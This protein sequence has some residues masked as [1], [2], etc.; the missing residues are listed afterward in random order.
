[1]SKEVK[2][3]LV[4]EYTPE[5][6]EQREFLTRAARSVL[7]TGKSIALAAELLWE[8]ESGEGGI[9]ACEWGTDPWLP[10]QVFQLV[11]DIYRK[12][13][14]SPMEKDFN[15]KTFTFD[16]LGNAERLIASFKEGEI[17]FC[18]EF[19]TW[20]I[21]D[22]NQ[23]RFVK[24]GDPFLRA[25]HGYI[26]EQMLEEA[27]NSSNEERA[28]ALYKWATKSRMKHRV[29]AA[30]NMAK[31]LVLISE[32]RLDAQP[33]LFACE[34]GVIDLRT[35]ELRDA[36]PSDL[37]SK[38]GGPRFDPESLR[39]DVRSSDWDGF[40]QKSIPDEE[41]RRFLQ[42]AAGYSLTGSTIE[43]KFFYLYGRPATGKSTFVSA[44]MQVLGEYARVADT[45]TFTRSSSGRGAGAAS[46][47][48]ARLAGARLVVTQEVEEGERFAS[49]LVSQYT[50]GDPVSA[51]FL[52]GSTFEF[53]PKFKLWIAANHR[54]KVSGSRSGIWRRM[55]VI[56]MDEVV[57]V[58]ERDPA[59]AMK[60]REPEAQ[61]AILAWA[62]EGAVA[63]INGEDL[64]PPKEVEEEGQAYQSDSDHVL[65]FVEEWVSRTEDDQ[66]RVPK[67]TMFEMYLAWCDAEGRER[68]MTKHQFSRRLTDMELESKNAQYN[69]TVQACWIGV[70]VKEPS[71][72]VKGS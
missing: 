38:T 58:S 13:P 30:V 23:K 72:S 71:I 60:L 56:P 68:R 21:W 54:A 34:N 47:D 15:E 27:M 39:G 64:L 53:R 37:L 49:A 28:R 19:D 66:D 7:T 63:W 42:L 1:M 4:G 9:Q 52:H 8:G 35:G 14:T 17:Y 29:D 50:G 55:M 41:T 32:S 2:R 44:F 48:L 11:D 65:T 46:E 16:D 57:P 25:R 45:S 26:M 10:E 59:L 36:T 51:R 24:E 61:S 5:P 12:P 18:P 33:E 62:V 69:G 43:H 22:R 31:D 3:F 6:G 67:R 20:L 70:T 40:L